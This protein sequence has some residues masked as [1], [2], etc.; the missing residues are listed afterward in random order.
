RLG[1]KRLTRAEE[2]PVSVG[3][4]FG[5][6]VGGINLPFPAKIVTQVL[7]PIDL[8]TQFGKNPDIGEVDAHVRKVMQTALD[9]LAAERRLPILG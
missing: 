8:T 1:L 5:L 2:V 6:S 7:P 9:R 3:F 4:P